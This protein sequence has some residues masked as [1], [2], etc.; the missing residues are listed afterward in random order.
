VA[1]CDEVTITW[2]DD[3]AEADSL[4]DFFVRQADPDYIS[5]GEL[6]L[7]RAIDP[8]HWS[9]D[10]ATLVADE[11]RG[12]CENGVQSERRVVGA[13][14]ESRLAAMAVVSFHRGFP[15]GY[16]VLEDL[17]VD[18]ALRRNGI[19][20]AV[21]KWIE[22]EARNAGCRRIFLESSIRN[23]D[24]HGFFERHGFRPCS[25]VMMKSVGA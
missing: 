11:I 22:K 17:V 16:L 18:K 19:G 1:I 14:I 6:Q 13:S 21:L 25:M 23:R 7:G 2:R 5:H 10:L 3:P 12:A 24:A 15:S 20:D 9:P 8:E 4:A